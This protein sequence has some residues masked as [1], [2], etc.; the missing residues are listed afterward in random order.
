M[1]LQ[2]L[3]ALALVALAAASLARR[4]LRS[5]APKA[6]AGCASGCAS[7][8]SA[9]GAGVDTIVPLDSLTRAN[10]RPPVAR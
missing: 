6:G 3:I 5:L 10:G 2:D 4:F 7:C 8:P 1:P 9:R